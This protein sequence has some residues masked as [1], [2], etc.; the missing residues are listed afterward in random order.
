MN[1]LVLLKLRL[2]VYNLVSQIYGK[3]RISYWDAQ[4]VINKPCF[5]ITFNT[6][7]FLNVN[8]LME[9]HCFILTLQRDWN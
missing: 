9:N 5:P 4:K 7:E 8:V 1:K 6:L 3:E 2:G